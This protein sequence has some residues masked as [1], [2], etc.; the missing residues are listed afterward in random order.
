MLRNEDENEYQVSKK[1]TYNY[2]RV[3]YFSENLYCGFVGNLLRDPLVMSEVSRKI[4]WPRFEIWKFCFV[5][6]CNE[7]LKIISQNATNPQV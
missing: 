1:Y 4:S 3:K 5:A 6:K 2:F 7:S